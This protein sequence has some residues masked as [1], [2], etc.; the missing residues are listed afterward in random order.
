[1]L[2]QNPKPLSGSLFSKARF[3]RH[4][5]SLSSTISLHS[6]SFTLNV[7]NI[8]FTPCCSWCSFHPGILSSISQE[9]FSS[10]SQSLGRGGSSVPPLLWNQCE[11]AVVPSLWERSEHC[12]VVFL[13]VPQM[14]CFLTYSYMYFS[15]LPRYESIKA[16]FRNI[17]L[18]RE[19]VRFGS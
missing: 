11:H 17:N 5:S 14:F 6:A 4:L 3:F 7:S 19:S 2:A 12:A 16:V 13:T 18:A 10:S 9:L 1:M 8:F 15:F